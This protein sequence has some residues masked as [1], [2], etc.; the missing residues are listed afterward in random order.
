MNTQLNAIRQK[1]QKKAMPLYPYYT[2]EI[3]EELVWKDFM[4]WF[5]LEYKHPKTGKTILQEF[6]ENVQLETELK[7]KMLQMSQMYFGTFK[8]IDING[9]I[10][11][12]QDTK[13]GIKMLMELMFFAFA[14]RQ[15]LRVRIPTGPYE[16]KRDSEKIY[17][18]AVG[19]NSEPQMYLHILLKN[20][21]KLADTFHL[22]KVIKNLI[23][24][25][26]KNQKM[27]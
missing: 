2:K 24:V 17:L 15:R 25:T 7:D 3:P 9:D 8:L 10:V 19:K 11:N 18:R 21:V 5:L 27:N 26:M 6:V 1:M 13:K 22:K 14:F 20:L 12:I 23:W 4:D 16:T